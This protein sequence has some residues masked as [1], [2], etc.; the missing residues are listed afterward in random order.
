MSYSTGVNIL[1][2]TGIYPPS[3]GGPATYS[4]LLHD[5]LPGH[6]AKAGL[7]IQVKIYSFDEVR[8]LPKIIRH[9]SYFFGC[10]SRLWR[11][12][13]VFAQD[14][15]SAALPA[16]LAAKLS[17]KPFLVRVPGDYAWEQSVQRFGVTDSI[18]V[19]QEKKYGWRVE[20]LRRI[21]RFVVG[22]ANLVITPSRYFARLVGNWFHSSEKKPNIVPIYNGVDLSQ[23]PHPHSQYEPKTLISAGRL[24]PWKGFAGLI[25][26]LPRLSGWQLSIAGDGPEKEKLKSLAAE[27]GVADRITWLGS[28]SRSDL[29]ARI[30]SSQIFALNTSF[31]SF[32][33]QVVEAM[34]AGTPVIATN[35]GN[36]SEIIENGIDG[37]LITPDDATAL[38]KA[39]EHLTHDDFRQKITTSALRKAQLFSIQRT[40]DSLITELKVFMPAQ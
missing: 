34:A 27:L 15:V 35:I 30:Q 39:I 21:Q 2:A 28:I 10:L 4:K 11:A 40:L 14:T 25:R 1:V 29:I 26:A 16:L 37:I 8:H 31:E 20:F 17:R 22:H 33:F 3:V 23:I 6:A 5:V 9:I 7:D 36:L 18:D 12:D 32:S 13:I 19:F 24:V 38:V